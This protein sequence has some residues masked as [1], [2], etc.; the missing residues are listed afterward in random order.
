MNPYF[1]SIINALFVGIGSGLGSYFSTRYLIK[2]F[3]KIENKFK[4]K[5]K[6]DN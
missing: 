1:Q 3:E 5:V 6:E 2:N 4:S